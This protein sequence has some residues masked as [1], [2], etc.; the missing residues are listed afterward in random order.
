MSN[1][2]IGVC[3]YIQ[4]EVIVRTAPSWL[5][6]LQIDRA[7]HHVVC[8]VL[9]SHV[10]STYTYLLTILG[11]CVEYLLALQLSIQKMRCS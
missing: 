1:T 3:R 4:H 11:V 10:I 2:I 5:V 7:G 9:V 8:V 6:P